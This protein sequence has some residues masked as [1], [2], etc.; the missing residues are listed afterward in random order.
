MSNVD[1]ASCL[2]GLNLF[3][4]LRPCK[5]EL[6]IDIGYPTPTTTFTEIHTHHP[7]SSSGS[8]SQ[9]FLVGSRDRNRTI[10]VRGAQDSN[11]HAVKPLCPGLMMAQ[12]VH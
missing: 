10:G 12:G 8:T 7:S 1:V 2:P 3:G 4:A 9:R 5:M 6:T 11:L